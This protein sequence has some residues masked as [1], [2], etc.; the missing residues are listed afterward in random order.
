MMK[1]MKTLKGNRKVLA[2]ITVAAGYLCMVNM[3]INRRAQLIEEERKLATW[4]GGDECMLTHANHIVP[5]PDTKRT[6]LASYPGSGKRFTFNVIEALTDHVSSKCVKLGFITSDLR[7]LFF[8]IELSNVYKSWNENESLLFLINQSITF[9]DRHQVMTTTF[10]EME[11]RSCTLKQDI[12]TMMEHG[13]GGIPWIK[14]FCWSVI[15]VGRSQPTILCVSSWTLAPILQRG[16][17]KVSRVGQYVFSEKLHNL[18]FV[19]NLQLMAS[20]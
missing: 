19:L 20:W 11:Q 7:G 12:P 13:H 16:E 1:T 3:N 10:P 14:Y 9:Y 17:L 6:V 4:L 15:L 18:F 8:A 2:F 5:G